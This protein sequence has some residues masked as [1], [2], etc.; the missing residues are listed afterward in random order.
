MTPAHRQA[1]ATRQVFSSH[2]EI[3]ML[4]MLF[5]SWPQQATTFDSLLASRSLRPN[6]EK[7]SATKKRASGDAGDLDLAALSRRRP[8][9]SVTM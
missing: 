7:S 9:A 4:R 8:V 3:N 6:T 5:Q 2:A 1:S